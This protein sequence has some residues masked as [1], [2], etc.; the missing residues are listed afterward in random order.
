M[1]IPVSVPAPTRPATSTHKRHALAV[2]GAALAP[3]VV[4]LLAQATGTELKV[5][6]AGQPPMVVSLPF[7][8]ATAAAASLA[9]WGALAVLRRVTSHPRRLWTCLA[10]AAL[11]LS[12]GPV[13]AVETSTAART[14]LALMHIAVATILILGLRGTVAAHRPADAKQSHS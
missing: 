14:Y 4:W 2:A 8:V 3:T 6:L 7:V 12:F 9:G 10:L 11:L 1:T 13:A 5:S